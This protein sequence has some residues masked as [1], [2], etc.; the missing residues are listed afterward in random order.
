[1]QVAAYQAHP[2]SG[3]V[4]VDA[5]S[6][7]G[8]TIR[9]QTTLPWK[10]EWLSCT[11]KGG[12]ATG[13]FYR[14]LIEGNFICT[15]SQA[16]IPRRVLEKIGF[17]DESLAVSSDYDLYLRI[18]ASYDITFVNRVLTSWRYL[19][20]SASG[21]VELRG[22]RYLFD[23]VAILKKHRFSAAP[24]WRSFIRQIGRQKLFVAAQTAYYFGCDTDT[25][26][27]ARYLTKLWARNPTEL[28]PLVFFLGL[29]SPPAVRRTFG[30]TFRRLRLLGSGVIAR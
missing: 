9:R 1:V 2:C 12:L 22:L 5:R 30:A 24:M 13:R 20:T 29:S 16:M 21:P 10:E 6:F 3:L 4:V 27:A 25:G 23:D 7:G 8:S 19:P 11:L 26:W 28:W 14:E 18:A 17:S 15:I